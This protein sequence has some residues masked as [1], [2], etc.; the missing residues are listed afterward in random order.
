MPGASAAP[1]I[2]T[3]RRAGLS[4]SDMKSD[5]ETVSLTASF[6][7]GRKIRKLFETSGIDFTAE[8]RGVPQILYRYRHRYGIPV[9]ALLFAAGIFFSSQYIWCFE[10]TGNEVMTDEE[11]IAGLTELGCGIGAR[12]SKIAFDDVENEFAL[13]SD[14]TA[15][16]SVNMK[17]TT[18]R[19][20]VREVKNGAGGDKTGKCAN[21]VAKESGEIVYLDVSSGRAVVKSGDTVK[22][23]ELLVSGVNESKSGKLRY[24]YAEGCVMARVSRLIH[25]E[26]S[27]ERTKKVYTGRETVDREI[28]IFGK[29]INLFGKGGKTGENCDMIVMS[30]KLSF[31]RD[32]T[33]PVYVTTRLYRE[34][35]TVPETVTEEEAVAA[36]MAAFR[37]EMDEALRDAELLEK[38]VTTGFDAGVYYVDCRLYVL[39]DIAETRTVPVQTDEENNGTKGNQRT[40]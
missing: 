6:L 8:T 17:G 37:R 2:E 19:V 18:A 29:V 4:Y 7:M 32:E 1:A 10:I 34:Y 35:E 27:P 3:I 36:G 31:F 24:E 9:G 5:G 11:I 23:G 15:W 26:I 20:E 25:V 38:T 30:E 28:N 22:E 21:L 39:T 12:R 33:L 13:R 40:E 14:H 16:I